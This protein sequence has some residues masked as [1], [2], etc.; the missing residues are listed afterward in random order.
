M[1]IGVVGKTNTGKSSF[2][3][4][5]TLIDV[6]IA[7]RTFVTIKPNVGM[8]YVTARCPHV[9]LK[10]ACRPNNALCAEGTR[11]IPVK[12]LDVAGLV[13]GA[14]EGRGLGNQ[15]LNDLV[16]T[17]L[18]VHVVDASG[19]TDA[20]GG[21]TEGYDPANDVR[22][23]ENEIELWFADVIKRNIEKIK[24]KGKAAEVLAGLGI[25]KE[26]VE[27]AI[28]KAGLEPFALAHELRLVSKPIVIAA[29]KADLP[30]AKQNIERLK[31]E[32]PNLLIVPVSAESE[33][34]LRAAA[35]NGLIKYVPGS[36]DFEVTSADKLS[37]Q[38]SAALEFIRKNVLAKYGSTGVQNIINAAVFDL[39][40]YRA[41]YPVVDANKWTDNKGNVLPD[42][43]LMPPASTPRDLAFKIHADIGKGFL[44]AVDG[45]KKMRLGADYRLMDGD[46]ISIVSAAK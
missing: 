45:R 2:F 3:K 43:Y 46:V 6:E 11:L 32:F 5:A 36:S 26:H 38:Q 27:S 21:P 31:K 39:L 42:V 12:L 22:F 23:L 24:D 15:F 17:D 44:Y 35:K 40:K 8:G 14:H 25:R 7:N 20:E 28:A 29:N 16:P 19:T 33:I 30:R 37:K 18:L 9:E 4:A 41:V 34:A 1:Q 10:K 13:P